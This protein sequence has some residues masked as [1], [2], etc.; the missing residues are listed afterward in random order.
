MRNILCDEFIRP[1][2]PTGLLIFSTGNGPLSQHPHLIHIALQLHKLTL[3][4]FDTDAAR[5]S[6]I[7]DRH[8]EQYARHTA[9]KA[10]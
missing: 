10:G 9:P 1:K 8:R 7:D 6:D 4:L 5:H 3:P 2:P